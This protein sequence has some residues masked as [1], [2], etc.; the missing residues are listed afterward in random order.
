MRATRA[1]RVECV[2]DDGN[3]INFFGPLQ[4]EKEGQNDEQIPEA[5][6][7]AFINPP[8]PTS[9]HL[10]SAGRVWGRGGGCSRGRTNRE[11]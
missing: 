11:V 7:S 4:N 2:G 9:S 5:I 8:A 6:Y 10:R 3:E 1:L